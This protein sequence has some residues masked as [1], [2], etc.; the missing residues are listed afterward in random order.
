MKILHSTCCGHGILKEVDTVFYENTR[1]TSTTVYL[2]YWAKS[3]ENEKPCHRVP[4][5]LNGN[6]E[7]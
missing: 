5:T 7:R 3:G 4:E 2:Q 1:L 6:A